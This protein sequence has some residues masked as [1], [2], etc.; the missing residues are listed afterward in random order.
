MRQVVCLLYVL[1]SRSRPP[2]VSLP[3]P[4]LPSP[5][6]PK[7]ANGAPPPMD[8][9]ERALLAEAAEA[10]QAP[11]AAAGGGVAFN[12]APEAPDEVCAQGGTQ[13]SHG[14][15]VVLLLQLPPEPPEL[16]SEPRV[17]LT[18]PSPELLPPSQPQPLSAEQS[19]LC[20]PCVG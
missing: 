18:V 4:L 15:D 10:Q 19:T 2:L 1:C 6:A 8:D 20:P 11:A 3:L 5:P 14:Q 17:V 12:A 7:K 13:P 9:A 16:C